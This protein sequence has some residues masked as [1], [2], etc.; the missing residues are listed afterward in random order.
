MTVPVPAPPLVQ[1]PRDRLMDRLLSYGL[2]RAQVSAALG[3]ADAYAA[4]IAEAASLR[5]I[6]PLTAALEAVLALHQPI[7][8]TGI[9]CRSCFDAYGGRAVWPCAEYQAITAEL[10]GE[11]L[12]GLRETELWARPIA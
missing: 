5:D 10:P 12:P 11:S 6:P 1:D 2:T 8:Y 4:R 7:A 3:D 9:R